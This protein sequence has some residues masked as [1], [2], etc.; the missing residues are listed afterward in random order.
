[1]PAIRIK[2][3]EWSIFFISSDGEYITGARNKLLFI[4][5]IIR[6]FMLRDLKY[7]FPRTVGSCNV[8]E[9][10]TDR[11]KARKARFLKPL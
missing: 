11:P 3:A 4:I 9:I 8:Y 5:S 7:K 1:M 2:I 10:N 6:Y